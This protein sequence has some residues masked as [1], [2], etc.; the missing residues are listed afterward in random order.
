MKGEPELRV[1]R[2]PHRRTELRW[3]NGVQGEVGRLDFLGP[4]QRPENS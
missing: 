1:Q 2:V 3:Y 4:H